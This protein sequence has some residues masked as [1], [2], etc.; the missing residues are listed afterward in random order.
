[1]N[2]VH[3]RKHGPCNTERIALDGEEKMLL[4]SKVGEERKEEEG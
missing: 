1:M 3:R 2:G 4:S